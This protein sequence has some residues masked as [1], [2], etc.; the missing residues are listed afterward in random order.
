MVD[1]DDE[2][3][4]QYTPVYYDA[5]AGLPN[6]E[7][8]FGKH[9]QR[10]KT[11]RAQREEATRMLTFMLTNP[12]IDKMGALSTTTAPTPLLIKAPGNNN[13]V[14]F[15]LGIAPVLSDPFMAHISPLEGKLLAISQDIS[16]ATE[17]TLPITLP[18]NI[19]EVK[20][21]KAP[22]P[23]AFLAKMA[24]NDDRGD[25]K[26]WFVE[27]SVTATVEIPPAIPLPAYIAY[28]AFSEDVEAHIIWERLQCTNFEGAE[29]VKETALQFLRAAHTA[30]NQD[31]NKVQLANEIFTQRPTLPGKQWAKERVTH[32]FPT[33]AP[34]TPTIPPSTPPSRRSEIL[35]LAAAITNKATNT[36]AASTPE[37][38]GDT[39]EKIFKKYGLCT[40]D[41]ERILTMCGK[42]SGEEDSLPSW[43]EEI[44]TKHMLNDG[45]AGV[46]RKL[47][48]TGLK[49][50]EYPIPITSTII[51]MII[52]KTFSGDEDATTAAGAM[53]GLSPYTMTAMTAEELE[54]SNTY[55]AAVS[56]SSAATVE[57]LQRLYNKK[58]KAPS[59]FS[60]LLI[61]LR[62]FTNLLGRLF[63]P[64][65]P[66]FMAML[67][68]CIKPLTLM[69][70]KARTAM[71]ST[72]LASIMWAVYKQTK[73]F[74]MGQ[75]KGDEAM[76][77]E[78][79]CMAQHIT[80]KQNFNLLEVPVSIAGTEAQETDTE[81]AKSK[82]KK[83]DDDAS[84]P[85]P[86]KVPKKVRLKMEIHPFIKKD[87]TDALPRRFS[88]KNLCKICD[89]KGV[90]HV[91]PGTNLCLQGAL[92]G[93]CPFP[94]C[95]R[96]H[97]GALVTDDLATKALNLFDPFLKDPSLLN[98]RG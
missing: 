4:T 58:A 54:E 15:I 25:G 26:K 29:E 33:I 93:F 35:E 85:G 22:S 52:K 65:C 50:D 44:A 12:S 42:E 24:L 7:G 78:W 34:A 39:E 28:D 73:R 41:L 36:S 17:T 90:N 88:V 74:A 46:I 3:N 66:L 91:F 56:A 27:R 16:L 53:K 72:T 68:H 83:G 95:D 79:E 87:L 55:A 70:Q 30:H 69:T 11:E 9:L 48:S 59:T 64:T 21:I 63:G 14:R 60:A 86:P 51:N 98:T 2:S 40:L 96:V 32:L 18:D 75:M 45:K 71:A 38:A 57:D 97:D 89:I 76:V 5:E 43:L 6:P 82:R 84:A 1:S 10:E 37:L 77:A 81:K 94:S 23:E 49:F 67:S 20:V 19:M 13:K 92:K 8:Q 31:S 61:V 47:L 62:T 80:C